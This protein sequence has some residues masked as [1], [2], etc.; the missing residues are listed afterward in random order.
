M[1]DK[2]SGW[3]VE[4]SFLRRG[5]REIALDHFVTPDHLL[6]IIKM[7]IDA[8]ESDLVLGSLVRAYYELRRRGRD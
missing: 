3:R 1:T 8:G 6:S 4:S 2:M 7:H 5:E